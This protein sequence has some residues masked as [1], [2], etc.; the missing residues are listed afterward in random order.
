MLFGLVVAFSRWP[1]LL[2]P[3]FSLAYALCFCAGAFF[4]GR[5]AWAL[6]A[7]VLLTTDLMLSLHYRH[8]FP[9]AA[10]GIET[11][12]YMAGNYIGYALLV[13]LG[14]LFR[15]HHRFSAAGF[16][17]LLAGGLLGALLFYLLTN[18]AAW[19]LNPFRNPEYSRDLAGW[20]RALT[21]GTHGHPPTWEFFRNTLLS[22]GLFTSLFAGSW[23]ALA[24]ES[25]LEKG[26]QPEPKPEPEPSVAEG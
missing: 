8:A 15:R 6:P 10:F 19:F 18:T 13:G 17:T 1:G 26:E 5:L 24:S 11:A 20:I 14:S 21:F 4:P 25:P 3:N 23:Q 2:P 16:T 7:G 22:G 9:G 12:L